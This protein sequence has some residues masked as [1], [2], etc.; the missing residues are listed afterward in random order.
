MDQKIT[1]MK[2][3]RIVLYGLNLGHKILCEGVNQGSR[4]EQGKLN[5]ALTDVSR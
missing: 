2:D 3:L 4:V 1:A 5:T